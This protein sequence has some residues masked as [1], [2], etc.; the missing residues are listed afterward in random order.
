MHSLED[1]IN[2]VRDENSK[3]HVRE[4]ISAYNSGA[5]RAAIITTW[6]AV[7]FDLTAKI[8]ELADQSDK[9]AIEWVDKLTGAISDSSRQSLQKIESELLDDAKNKFS[10]INEREF[11]ELQRLYADRHVCAH[12]A[13]VDSETIFTA[14]PELVRSHFRAAISAVLSQPPTPGKQLLDRYFEAAE[15]HSWPTE[16]AQLGQYLH[17]VYFS[18][19]K[20]SLQSSV[21]KCTIKGILFPPK[22]NEA[23]AARMAAAAHEIEKINPGLFRGAL[24]QILSKRIS[25]D[26]IQDDGFLRL[27]AGLGDM[28]ILWICVDDS[29]RDRMTCTIEKASLSDLTARGIFSIKLACANAESAKMKRHEELGEES[30]YEELKNAVAATPIQLFW[31]QIL[32][33]LKSASSYRTAEE[34]VR[35]VAVPLAPTLD[36]VSLKDLANAIKNNNQIRLASAMPGYV[37]L[38][39]DESPKT[40]I[41]LTIWKELSEWLKAQ[42]KDGDYYRYLRLADRLRDLDSDAPQS[43]P[44]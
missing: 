43:G 24:K 44:T 12:P 23:T 29:T 26:S 1:L 8:R 14:S 7:A 39:F 3:A 15:S 35:D 21:T 9:A 5:F 37:D 28:D 22:G 33:Q 34:R 32:K 31:P 17:N 4:A 40:K 20:D 19:G 2:D 25:G 10:F 16:S 38:I 36:D 42:E 13:F 6:I 18:R 30:N 27:I 11:I 41:N